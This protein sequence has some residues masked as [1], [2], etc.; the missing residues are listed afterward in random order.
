MSTVGRGGNKYCR[1]HAGH[2]LDHWQVPACTYAGAKGPLAEEEARLV[3]FREE[4]EGGA[5]EELVRARTDLE[6]EAETS[7][8]GKLCATPFGVDVVG[9][10]EFV[11]LTGALV[12]GVQ[13]H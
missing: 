5:R 12:G 1:N 9:I 13:P 10:T 7:K 4:L 6:A 11:A 3:R 8:L 2:K